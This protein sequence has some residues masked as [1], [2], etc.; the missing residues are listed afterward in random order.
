ME[1]IHSSSGQRGHGGG[2]KV[3]DDPGFLSQIPFS[4]ALIPSHSSHFG[5]GGGGFFHENAMASG[6]HVGST[7][8]WPRYNPPQGG[9]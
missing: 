8:L 1:M 4:V 6:C 7:V 9:L 5:R 3:A 2:E